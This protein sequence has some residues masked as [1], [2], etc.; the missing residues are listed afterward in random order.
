MSHKGRFT[1]FSDQEGFDIKVDS[2]V[3]IAVGVPCLLKDGVVSTCTI[4]K[5][6]EPD[7]GKPDSR[8]GE[9]NHAVRIVPDQ[10]IDGRVYNAD[11]TPMGNHIGGDGKTWSN[12]SIHKGSQSKPED[13]VSAY[14]VLHRYAKQVIGAVS[15]GAYSDIRSTAIPHPFKIPYTFEDR[16]GVRPVQDRIRG[17]RIAIVGLGGSGAYVL[18]LIA[19]VP[20]KEI[21][22]LDSDVVEWHTLVRAP[23]GPYGRRNRNGQLQPAQSGLLLFQVRVSQGRD[24]RARDPSRQRIQVRRVS[25]GSFH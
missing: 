9:A 2:D 7:T 17:Q 23:G 25:F 18:D 24:P 19:K 21:H 3:V 11:G 10:A 8:I 20:V 16:S 5:S 14:A 13:D 15:A 6:Y 1:A 22:L 12:I 4:E